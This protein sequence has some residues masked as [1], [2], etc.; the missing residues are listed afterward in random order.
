MQTSY[1]TDFPLT[2]NPVSE[3]GIWVA[4]SGSV[5]TKRMRTSGGILLPDPDAASYDDCLAV[6]DPTKFNLGPTQTITWTAF[7]G[8]AM[9]D[10][11]FETHLRTA[12]DTTPIADGTKLFTY[13]C[14]VVGN[15]NSGFAKWFGVQG[16]FVI[17][18]F[19]SDTNGVPHDGIENGDKF[20]VSISGT[21]LVTIQIHHKKA[22]EGFA[23]SYLISE[24]QDST[25]IS[26]SLGVP[27]AFQSPYQSGTCGH[28]GDNVGAQA[29]NFGAS[30]TDIATS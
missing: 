20:Q 19:T 27:S 6:L 7:V 2:E 5:W 29:G 3:D 12:A 13:E 28:G 4:P 22:S 25:A 16:D 1:S 24:C 23:T 18:P 9:G 11:E 26:A 10:S 14:T 30:H 8:G 21:S 15:N 17:L